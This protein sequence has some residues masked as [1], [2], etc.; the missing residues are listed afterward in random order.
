MDFFSPVASSDP[1]TALP[2][3]QCAS[4]D[5]SQQFILGGLYVVYINLILPILTCCTIWADLFIAWYSVRVGIIHLLNGITYGL[6]VA[7]MQDLSQYRADNKQALLN[8]MWQKLVITH[9]NYVW[10][11]LAITHYN[12]MW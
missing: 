5:C 10:Q 2:I 1:L 6:L 3:S 7:G 9:Y 8:C 12:Y 11:V 4:M